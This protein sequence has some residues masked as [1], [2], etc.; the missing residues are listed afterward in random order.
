[1]E[2][3]MNGTERVLNTPLPLA[4][5]I[6]ITQITWIYVMTLPFQ[7]FPTLG[8]VTIPA[9]MSTYNLFSFV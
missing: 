7:L 5:A 3:A 1:M 8:W 2:D 9:S 4:Y 6:L